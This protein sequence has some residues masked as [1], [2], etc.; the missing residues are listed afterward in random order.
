MPISRRRFQKLNKLL[1]KHFFSPQICSF[2]SLTPDIGSRCSCRCCICL[3]DVA[4]IEWLSFTQQQQ[5]Q[6]Q[7]QQ[8]FLLM[9]VVVFSSL[10]ASPV[11][12]CSNL[13]K[14]I[15][16]NEQWLWRSSLRAWWSRGHGFQSSWLKPFLLLS[17]VPL[18]MSLADIQQYWQYQRECLRILLGTKLTK[19]ENSVTGN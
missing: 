18:N 15:F 1:S 2:W 8:H 3:T 6:Q 14:Y 16:L 5:Q 7:Q 13:V 17:N 4:A 11:L 10:A 19:V 9:R 12:D